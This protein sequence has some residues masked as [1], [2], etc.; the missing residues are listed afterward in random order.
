MQTGSWLLAMF[1]VSAAIRYDRI[2]KADEE[3]LRRNILFSPSW[4][5]GSC[6]SH[7]TGKAALPQ[8]HLGAGG[9]CGREPETN[10]GRR[11]GF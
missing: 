9:L 8:P 10:S 7:P 4:R 3:A 6:A 2:T 11:E 5:S 1:S